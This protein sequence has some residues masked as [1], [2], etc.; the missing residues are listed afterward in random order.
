MALLSKAVYVA[1][2]HQSERP[3]LFYHFVQAE[4]MQTRRSVN[5]DNDHLWDTRV[6]HLLSL[7][8]PQIY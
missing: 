2:F 3:Y 1:P 8:N 4:V 5:T 6:G 7:S